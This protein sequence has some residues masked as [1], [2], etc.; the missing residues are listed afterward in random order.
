MGRRGNAALEFALVAPALLLLI[1]GTIELSMVLLTNGSL[2]SAVARASRFGATG[3]GAEQDRLA[4]ISAILRN[5]TFGLTEIDAA[6]ISTR[7]YPTFTEIGQPEAFTDANGNGAYDAGEAFVDSNGNGR[8]DADMGKTGL[9]GPG[10]I[11]LYEVRYKS[12]LSSAFLEPMVGEVTYAASV[13][14]R[15]EPF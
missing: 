10:D 12:R 4:A 2:Q 6:A 1:A 13:A 15:N 11:V 7:V 9:G 5:R 3:Q 8:W 14:V